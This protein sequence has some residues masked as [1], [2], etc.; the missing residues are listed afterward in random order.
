MDTLN[1]L[2]RKQVQNRLSK[3]FDSFR[4]EEINGVPFN[5]MPPKEDIPLVKQVSYDKDKDIFEII[6]EYKST[7]N[8]KSDGNVNF[9]EDMQGRLVGIQVNEIKKNDIKTVTVE[10]IAT[11]DR[12]IQAARVN[13]EEQNPKNV[14]IMDMEQRKADFFKDIVQQEMPALVA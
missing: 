3:Y 8:K 5:I 14:A 7:V 12:V 1:I 6:F 9:I 2:D 4:Q 13:L 11:L 10:I